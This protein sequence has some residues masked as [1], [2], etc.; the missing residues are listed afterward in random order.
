MN[1]DRKR[2]RMLRAAPTKVMSVPIR[3]DDEDDC[4]ENLF[5]IAVSSAR[6]CSQNV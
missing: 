5:L 4:M 1:M 3:E 6:Q 2:P